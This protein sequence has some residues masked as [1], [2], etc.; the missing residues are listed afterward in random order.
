MNC[1]RLVAALLLACWAVP[2]AAQGYASRTEQISLKP[3]EFV[4]FGTDSLTPASAGMVGQ[5]AIVVSIPAQL[6]Y[7][8]RDDA[9]IGV[10]TVST[11]KAGKDTPTGDF[12]ILQKR[13]FHRSNLYSNAPMPWMQR[14][15]WDGIA[16][17]RPGTCPAIR[18]RNGCIRL[19]PAFAKQ[20][21]Q[22]T[23]LGAAVSVVDW[24]IDEPFDKRWA[25]PPTLYADPGQ[26]RTE[27]YDAV[28]RRHPRRRL[29]WSRSRD[30]GA[31]PSA[32]WA[33]G[34]GQGS[35]PADSGK[36]QLIWIEYADTIIDVW[37]II[38]GQS[39]WLL[40][41]GD[42]VLLPWGGVPMPRYFFDI[43]DGQDFKDLQGSE[44]AD[45]AAARIESGAIFGRKS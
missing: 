9:L 44:F 12:T 31:R 13:P 18:R 4:W 41:L 39:P 35:R 11:G 27:R 5:V 36:F 21:F 20:L 30:E 3:G 8:Y 25:E 40:R 24:Q 7:V 26:L 34:A 15:T 29:R 32:S 22:L 45:L 6:A 2:A 38:V 17:P 33:T 19:P 10:S 37:G 14:L 16:L 42:T 28:T 23:E 43:I 1:V